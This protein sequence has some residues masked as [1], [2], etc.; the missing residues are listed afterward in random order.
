MIE[1]RTPKQEILDFLDNF[2][3]AS[4]DELKSS[5]DEEVADRMERIKVD[6]FSRVASEDEMRTKLGN[7]I[8]HSIDYVIDA[9]TLY[10]YTVEELEPDEKT[11]IGKRIE[12]LMRVAF[13]LAKGDKLDVQLAGEEV[14]IKTTMGRS[15]MFSISSHGHINLLLTYDEGKSLFS[16]GMAY[17]SEDKLGARNRDRKQSLTKEH[18][19][20]I[21]WIF[22]DVT[23]PENFL[24]KIDHMTLKA[25]TEQPSGNKRV[26]QLFKLIQGR[27]IPRHSICS[28]ANQKDPLKRA[29]SNGGARDVLWRVGIM[30]LSGKSDADNMIAQRAIHRRLRRDEMMSLH[31]DDCI[32]FK[33]F[34][35]K[36]LYQEE[37]GLE[38]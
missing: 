15:W 19:A 26:T 24:A 31:L 13:K 27:P 34:S 38:N 11:T 29:R 5:I 23:Y 9:P 20:G 4:V 28:V 25:I 1:N 17:V 22:Q 33:N 37:H 30:V 35:A 18:R 7:I 36:R 8:R 16:F 6:L 2:D 14:D 12:R 21:Q 10:R 3:V 32:D